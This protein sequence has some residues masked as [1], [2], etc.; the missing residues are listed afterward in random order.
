MPEVMD[1]RVTAADGRSVAFSFDQRLIVANAVQMRIAKQPIDTLVVTLA[2]GV[3]DGS[4]IAV[5]RTMVKSNAKLPE[6]AA[7][8]AQIEGE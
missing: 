1:L 6:T 3:L 8:C 4:V 5:G 7:L 2:T